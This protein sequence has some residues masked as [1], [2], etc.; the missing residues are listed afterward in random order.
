MSIDVYAPCLCG[1]GKKLKFC[2]NAIVTE[3]IRIRKLQQNHQ[4]LQALQLLDDLEK[5]HPE[6]TW[7]LTTKATALV[8]D[9]R[10]VEAKQILNDLLESNPDHLLALALSAMVSLTTDG[11]E[12]SKRVIHRAFQ[13]CAAV[14]PDIIFGMAMG[15][16]ASLFIQQK[17][18]ASRQHLALAMRLALEKSQPEIFRQLLEFDGDTEIPYPL[19]GVHALAKFA[20]D[21][22]EQLK[23]AEKGVRL[24]NIGCWALSAR[25][26]TNMTETNPNDAALWQNVGLCHAWDGHEVEAAKAFHK[27]AELYEDYDTAVEFET[28]AQLLDLGSSEDVL[29]VKSLQFNV[30]SVG[31]ILTILDEQDRLVRVQISPDEVD[32]DTILPAAIYNLLDRSL[33]ADGSKEPLT[34]ETIPNVL[35]EISVYDH[36]PLKDEPA[37][38]FI[39]GF[40]GEELQQSQAVLEEAVGEQITSPDEEESERVLE[41]LPRDLHQLHWRWFF[42]PN[43]PAKLR[44]SLEKQKWDL[45]V[46]D[47]WPDTPLSGIQGK[48]PLDASADPDLKIRLAAA[49]M[50]LDSYADRNLQILDASPLYER[51]GIAAP[52]QLELTPQT[53]W[54]AL[55]AMQMHRLPIADLT[56]EQLAGNLNRALLIHHSDYLYKILTE[57]LK[58]PACVEKIDCDRAY[59]TLAEL[60]RERSQNKEALEWIVKGQELAESGEN[61]FE[62]VLQW[63]LREM[64]SRLDDLDGTDDPELTS[65]LK[66]LWDYYGPKVPQLRT[67]LATLVNTYGLKSPWENGNS[68]VTPQT[69]SE[70]PTQEGIWTPDAQSDPASN[71]GEKK[72][73]LPGQ[74]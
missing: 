72:L 59:L 49:V 11:F 20:P 60:C 57:I 41:T 73:W 61:T 1:S 62:I 69:A 6:N 42:P 51:L 53:S 44:K 38:I 2:C 40:E 66:H 36:N 50:V 10:S 26:F 30:E 55:S 21:D 68:I 58:R 32:E 24:S 52:T 71:E 48:T 29:N 63:K 12:A 5:K 64:V 25:I 27:A 22:D 34:I 7:I 3:M 47:V 37:R 9:G 45:L 67:Y 17:Y 43:T 56:D 33:P 65:L 35:A 16:A 39:I 28:L 8:E 74:D 15:I 13:R 14:F 23:E 19:R 31:K 18:M 70:A 54:N 4:A 46:Q